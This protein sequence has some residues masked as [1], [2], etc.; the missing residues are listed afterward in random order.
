MCRYLVAAML[1][2]YSGD[3]VWGGWHTIGVL[4][5]DVTYC[6]K[7]IVYLAH[8]RHYRQAS[9]EAMPETVKEKA[10]AVSGPR[11]CGIVTGSR[12]CESR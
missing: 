4:L 3:D 7:P 1:E 9:K 12:S 11:S 5:G 6:V 10:D 8:N 2:M